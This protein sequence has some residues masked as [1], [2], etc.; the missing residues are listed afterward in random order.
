MHNNDMNVQDFHSL[1]K[2][3]TED[4]L[5]EIIKDLHTQIVYLKNDQENYSS[6]EQARIRIDTLQ[7]HEGITIEYIR[8]AVINR[9]MQ[10]VVKNP[11]AIQVDQLPLWEYSDRKVEYILQLKIQTLLNFKKI[12]NVDVQ[13]IEKLEQEIAELQT[14]IEHRKKNIIHSME[15]D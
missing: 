15:K 4:E 5:Y 3:A 12:E 11:E 7:H 14:E 8:L 13:E 9:V 1:C 6:E 10:T 2:N